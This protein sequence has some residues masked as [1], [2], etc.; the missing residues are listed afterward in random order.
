MNLDP[1]TCYEAVL[2]HDRRF[3]GWFFIGVTSTG[4]YCRP[5]CPV[6]PPKRENC[7]FF[8]SQAAAE[9][10]GFRPCMRC[11]PELA[12]GNGLLDLSGNLAAAAAS[13]IEHGFLNGAGV[14]ALA[15]RIGVTER[16][17]RRIFSAQFGVSLVEFAQTQRLLMAKRLL[18][19]TA[20]PLATV[21]SA[22]GFGSVRRFNDLFVRRYGF[23]PSRLRN[24]SVNADGG[25]MTFTLPYRPPFA[26]PAL[27][28]FL[29]QRRIAGVEHVD[30]HVYARTVELPHG[31]GRLSGWL[32][33]SHV[34]QRCTIAVTVAPT[35]TPVIP[36]VLARVRQLLDLD[37]RPDIVDAH[38]GPLAGALPG[39]RVPGAFDGFE[40]ALQAILARATPASETRAQM[41]R[42]AAQFGTRVESAP[43]CLTHAFV[44]AA[45]LASVPRA[46]LV[47]QGIAPARAEAIRALASA[48]AQEDIVLEP[49]APL[50]ETLG[51][52]RVLPAM[53]E[54]TVQCIAM[55]AL[56]WP[57]AFPEDDPVL[58]KQRDASQWAP[59]RA[60][61][62]LHLWRQHEEQAS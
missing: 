1:D 13:L 3:D 56:G 11:R 9:Q 52:L 58:A 18:T 33:L 5:V 54:W 6:R 37:S 42:L 45:T 26:W 25:N 38:L 24:G 28:Q 50:E 61:A 23:N 10:A 62:A 29:A 12:P 15:R 19:D 16:H 21:A 22:A 14:D 32:T 8:P 2:A 46:T 48:V 43:F 44:S 30:E 34:P 47:E 31:K 57:N 35:L 51:K 17:L 27:V 20:L 49:M 4:V 7:R 60:Y 53:D 39:L 36:I 55:R 41:S 59:W 40:V